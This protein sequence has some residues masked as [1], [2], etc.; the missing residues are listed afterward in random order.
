MIRRLEIKLQLP[1]DVAFGRNKSSLFHGVISKTI[2]TE[3]SAV[4]HM[5]SL[6]PYSQYIL[7]NTTGCKWVINTLDDNAGEYIL[8]ALSRADTIYLEHNGLEVGLGEKAITKTSA[9]D[10]FVNYGLNCKD[11]KTEFVFLTPT[12]FKSN[13]KYVNMP[14]AQLMLQSLI[15]KYD[16][17][18]GNAIYSDEL[19]RDINE[20][21]VISSFSIKSTFFPLEGI[22]IPAFTGR[23]TLYVKGG[24]ALPGIVRMLG[25]YGRYSGI[26]IKTALGMGAMEIKTRGETNE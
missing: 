19:I 1:N 14:S 21:V 10:I 2:P 13:E 12:A 4:L 24:G 25:E 11:K 15:Q 26:G 17:F 20:R 3:Y 18:S 5:Q 6:H 8:N 22:T 9:D 16:A 7:H 23:V